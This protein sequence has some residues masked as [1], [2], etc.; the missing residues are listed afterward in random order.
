MA[1]R[2]RT[3]HLKRMPDK[4]VVRDPEN[5][6][7]AILISTGL[8][9]CACALCEAVFYIR[10]DIVQCCPSCGALDVRKCWTRP[11]VV[12]VPESEA[13]FLCWRKR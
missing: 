2:P 8:L 5:G 7:R 4:A 3:S 9:E 11:Q 6:E 13:S 12:L 1:I 10:S